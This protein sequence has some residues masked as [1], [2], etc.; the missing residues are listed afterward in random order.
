VAAAAE[1]AQ[2]IDDAAVVDAA[3]HHDVD[4]HRRQ[5]RLGRR[6]D[7]RQD[8]GDGEVDVV[9]AAERGVVERVEA[10]G[11]AVQAGVAQ[12]ARFLRREERAVGGECKILH[13][14]NAGQHLHQALEVAPQ[15]RFAAGEAD[16]LRPLAHE[17]ARH[18]GDLL[19]G[20]QRGA[21]QVA[22]PRRPEDLFRHAVRAA[23]VTP[24]CN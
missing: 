6:I 3:L 21:R 13:P 2:E 19:E 24:V 20:Q 22:V 11:D 10:D 1:A 17:E 4:L 12:H 23:K 14:A 15:Q 18:A 8:G 9:H 5:P 7:G 16:L